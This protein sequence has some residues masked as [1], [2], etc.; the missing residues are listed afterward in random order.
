MQVRGTDHHARA[1]GLA[2]P[3][4][5][6]PY[7]AGRDARAADHP[8]ASLHETRKVLHETEEKLQSGNAL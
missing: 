4:A 1:G 8:R 6:N 5:Q 2:G 3:A 7:R